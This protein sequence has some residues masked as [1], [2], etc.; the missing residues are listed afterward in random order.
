MFGVEFA[1]WSNTIGGYGGFGYDTSHVKK[2]DK[3]PAVVTAAQ[4]GDLA[5]V[6]QLVK[7]DIGVLNATQRWTEVDFKGSGFTKEWEWHGLTPLATA[8][9][10]GHPAIVRFLLD[11]GADPTLEGC[12][13]DNVYLDA[14]K[15][16]A[17]GLKSRAQQAA[18]GRATT[19]TSE[20]SEQCGRLLS[21]AAPFWSRASYAS[22]HFS[23]QRSDS[24]WSNTPTE[25]GTSRSPCSS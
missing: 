13:E 3:V 15:A 10:A 16:Q 1:D 25:G 4:K 5:K 6:R 24:G 21:A 7:A 19:A 23:K 12:P 9:R 11:V 17:E 14:Y 20:Q 2:D 8:A 18:G 22:S